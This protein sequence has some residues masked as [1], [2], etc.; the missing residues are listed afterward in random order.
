MTQDRRTP[1]YGPMHVRPRQTTVMHPGEAW[2]LS[3]WYEAPREDPA[4]P[5]VYTY[6]DAMSYAPGAEVGFHS[7][8]TAGRWSLEIWR[9][10]ARP[11]LV[12]EAADLPGAFHPTPEQAYRTGCGWPVAY[13]W[14][15]PA[16]LG[17]G[18][19]RVVSSCDQGG[20]SRFVQHHFFV[21]TPADPEP[22]KGRFLLILPT[23]TWIAYNDWGG[24]NSYD[25]IDG[26]DGNQFSPELS[27][28]RPWTRGL[29]WLPPGAPRLC[30]PVKRGPWEAP[31][32][33][34]KEWAYTNGFAQYFASAGWAQ[35]DRHFVVWAER[36][37]YAFDMITQSDLHYRP[38]ILQ[39]YGT[40][41]IVGHDEYWTA[42]MRRSVDAFVEAGGRMAR[43]A[44]N[45]LWQVRLEDEGRRQ[46]C[47][48]AR[49]HDEDPVAGGAAADRL[50]CAWEDPAVNWPGAA[51]F[52]V[53]GMR[54]VYA[55]WGGFVP[56]GSRGFTVYRHRHWAFAG[57]DTHYGD[58]IGGEAGIFAYEVDGLDYTFRDGLPYPTH[59]DGAPEGLEILAMAP[60]MFVEDMHDGEGF[61]YYLKDA[62]LAR[63]AAMFG[64]TDP[65][66]ID[67]HRYGCGMVVS[68][69]RGRGEVFT[70]G[71]CEWL[72]GLA[73]GDFYTQQ[74]TRN[75]IDR[76]LAAGS[77]E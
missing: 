41:V 14:T 56:R 67:R 58:V 40:A 37:G 70:A 77:G 61:R 62:G 43:F 13:R 17:S 44:G 18:F 68:M 48:K 50:T 35:F 26:P 25:G 51:T 27:F 23:S 32:Y 46:V 10:G 57:T 1:E 30:D 7:S 63:K 74:I 22:A 21:V 52:G 3:H 11:V 20:G 47:Y 71:S 8:S 73:K 53:N 28:Q 66:G 36:E 38:E 33:P 19:Y 34:T 9:D 39:R 72:T 55:S 15:L 59:T 42:E 24:A 6:T 65:E 4:V 76:F 75:V 12:H 2:H 54:G 16:D 49:A 60:A 45:F 31:R 29:V 69:R 64:T 5:E